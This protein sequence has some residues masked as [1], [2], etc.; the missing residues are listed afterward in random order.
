MRKR[1][2]ILGLALCLPLMQAVFASDW[3]ED[4]NIQ[5]ERPQRPA[6]PYAPPRHQQQGDQEFIDESNLPPPSTV[7]DDSQNRD[8]EAGRNGLRLEGNVSR[9]ELGKNRRGAFNREQ[10][11]PPMRLPPPKSVS[12][13]PSVFKAWLEKT[14]PEINSILKNLSKGA[15]VEVQGRWDNSG[16]VLSSFGIPHV[17]VSTSR[18]TKSDLSQTKILVVD[19]AGELDEPAAERVRKFVHDGGY[20][21]TTDW[22]L[23][24]CLHKAIPN[25]V[26]WNGGYTDSTQARIVD[27]FAPDPNHSLLAGAVSHAHWKLDKKSQTMLV[28]NAD[29]VEVLARVG[30]HHQL[31]S[32]ALALAATFRYG[33]GRALHLV[34]HFDNN[35]DR[36]FNNLLPDPAPGIGISLRQAIAGN[37]V[38]E[39]LGAEGTR[40]KAEA[41]R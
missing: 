35:S 10:P 14:H 22:A 4:E 31:D 27:A 23:D 16:H 29:E 7:T 28:R 21:L 36:A 38:A 30:R 12:V 15:V 8:S 24:G 1:Y 32:G 41:D 17:R 25:F 33:K 19:C 18:L 9:H 26:E 40:K 6:R 34:G 11:S 2:L 20:L 37:F 39:A 13:A 5:V 3:V